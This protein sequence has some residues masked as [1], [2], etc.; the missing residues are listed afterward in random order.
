M[1]SISHTCIQKKLKKRLNATLFH[2]FSS[3]QTPQSKE[4]EVPKNKDVQTPKVAKK[5]N[6]RTR[7]NK[8]SKVIGTSKEEMQEQ[9]VQKLQKQV[10]AYADGSLAVLPTPRKKW[11]GSVRKIFCACCLH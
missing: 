7:A 9:K 4:K 8:Y 2:Y 11:N 10:R 5:N 3:P 6:V 1:F